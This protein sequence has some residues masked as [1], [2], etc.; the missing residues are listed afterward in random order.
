[1]ALNLQK[2]KLDT[3]KQGQ[4]KTQKVMITISKI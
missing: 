1:M 2:K 4:R 3:E